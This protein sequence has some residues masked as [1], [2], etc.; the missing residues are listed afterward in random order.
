MSSFSNL[1]QSLGLM[2]LVAL[3]L[4]AAVLL[5]FFAYIGSRYGS[6]PK[7]LLFPMSASTTRPK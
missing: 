5:G 1:V 2:R 6:E 3:A 7:A 4:V